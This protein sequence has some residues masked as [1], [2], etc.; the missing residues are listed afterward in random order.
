MQHDTLRLNNF[1]VACIR[2]YGNHC[3]VILHHGD[4]DVPAIVGPHVEGEEVESGD[5]AEEGRAAPV[6]S[7]IQIGERV[8]EFDAT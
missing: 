7:P 2:R 8:D 6:P 4:T 3:F 1:P 5:L